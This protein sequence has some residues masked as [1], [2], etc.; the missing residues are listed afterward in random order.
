M[1]LASC[2]VIGFNAQK[3]LGVGSVLGPVGQLY[4]WLDAAQV[5]IAID[6]HMHTHMRYNS[7]VNLLKILPH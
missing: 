2:V 5:G 7:F 6:V 1:I 4:W 3:R